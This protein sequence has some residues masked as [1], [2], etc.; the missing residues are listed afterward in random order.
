[1][2]VSLFC[3]FSHSRYSAL[4]VPDTHSL[5]GG[6]TMLMGIMTFARLLSRR[7]FGVLRST[8]SIVRAS[9]VFYIYQHIPLMVI[10]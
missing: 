4:E 9:I 10:S 2:P 8:V 7:V 1:V 6:E 3:L 5:L